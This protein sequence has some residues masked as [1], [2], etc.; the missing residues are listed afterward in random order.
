LEHNRL[1]E[2]RGVALLGLIKSAAL[3]AIATAMTGVLL[4][5][6]A[7]PASSAGSPLNITYISSLTGPAAAE[8]GISE[9]GCV[10]RVDLQNSE[11]GVNGRKLQLSVVD[12][13]TNPTL[14]QNAVEAAVAKNAI[15]IVS[16]SPFFF[17]AAKDAQ[18]AGMPVTG[19]SADGPEWGEEPYTNMFD[20]LRGSEDPATPVNSV[21]GTFL[22]QHGG[23]M[24]GTYGYGVSPLSA[25]E[26]T[27]AADSFERA[28]GRVGVRDTSVPFGSVAF[29]A[30]ALV[31][32]EHHVDAVLPTMDNDSNFALLTALEQAGVKLKAALLPVGYEPS[33]VGSPA[34]PALQGAYF[35]SLARPFSL[36]N[37]GTELMSAALIKYAHFSKSE[38]P[39]FS[40]DMS[41]L[42]CDLLINGLQRAGTNPTRAAVIRALRSIRAYN[43]NGLLPV[44]INYSTVFG[45]DLPQC[46]WILRAGKS[47]FVPVSAKPFCGTDFKNT[48]LRQVS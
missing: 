25:E 8:Y 5:G 10:A 7:G 38:F 44:T 9:Q 22:K 12:D 36:P 41:W 11:G 30:L 40:Q 45:H 37:A 31:A 2:L 16:N 4:V 21:F 48:S 24:I 26:A 27:G 35:M 33:V 47:G 39:S 23:T 3:I 15:G 43:G 46:A 17:L 13:E 18:A 29:T 1:I 34:W 14:T 6:F 28:G 32:K 20:A 42:G 19:N